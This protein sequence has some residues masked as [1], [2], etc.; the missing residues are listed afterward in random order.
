MKESTMDSMAPSNTRVAD[1]SGR[2]PH[3]A[4]RIRKSSKLDEVCYDIRGVEVDDIYIG[5]GVSELVMLALQGLL[6]N[7]DEVL[8]PVPDFPLW[9]AA[10]NLCGGRPVHYLCDEA[11]AWAPDLEDLATKVPPRIRNYWIRS[12]SGRSS[13]T[14]SSRRFSLAVRPWPAVG[15]MFS[16]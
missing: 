4:G 7:D 15:K 1:I 2:M 13:S 5:N 14:V 11:A 8:I 10:V 9:S 12:R 6:E 3:A 16:P